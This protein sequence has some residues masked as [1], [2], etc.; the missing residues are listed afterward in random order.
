MIL[1]ADQIAMKLPSGTETLRELARSQA[2]PGPLT[3][4]LAAALV[5][6]PDERQS[7]LEEA[8]VAVR[9]E[10]VSERLASILLDFSD[11]RGP[12]N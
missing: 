7:L 6:D 11:R 8:D 9:V 12:A 5:T 1:L 2:E 10:R 3:D 4:V